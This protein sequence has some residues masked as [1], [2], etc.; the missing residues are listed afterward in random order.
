MNTMRAIRI[1]K[2]T[3][4]EE[5]VFSEVQI[6]EIKP[7]WVLVKIMAF[8]LNHSEQI[9]REF[10][11]ERDYITKPIIPGIECVGVIED[12]SDSGLTKGQKVVSLMGGM[13]RS[14]DGSYAEYALL[15]LHHVFPVDTDISWEDLGAIPETYYTAWGSLMQRLQLKP[16]D[17]LL[18]RGATC[19]LGY[20]SIQLAKTL[21][22][23][24]IATTHREKY[25][26]LLEEAGVDECVL[27]DGSIAGKCKGANKALELIGCKT[28]VDTMRAVKPGGYVCHTGVLGNVFAI[29]NFS[30]LNAIPNGVYLTGFHSNYPT[31]KDMQDILDFM[32]EHNL[33]PLKGAVYSF[34]DLKDALIDLDG[35]KVQGKIVIVKEG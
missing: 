24:V 7:G 25:F 22:C 6:P 13:G 19:A 28:I 3:K 34:D 2:P 9:L 12:P 32:K 14:Y 30:P 5:V 15:P 27:D 18:I 4:A 10:E 8:G 26:P 17:T 29:S 35:H 20:V 21:G 23:R 11:I 1:D 31:A 16:E 33:K